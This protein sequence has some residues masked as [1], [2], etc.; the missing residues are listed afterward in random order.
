MRND[1]NYYIIALN[2]SP[3]IIRLNNEML[4]AGEEKLTSLSYID[5]LT[6]KYDEITF[7][8]YLYSKQIIKNVNA[9][10]FIVLEYTYDKQRRLKFHDI[11]FKGQYA[12]LVENLALTTERKRIIVPSDAGYLLGLF[13]NMYGKDQK[14]MEIANYIINE[15]DINALLSNKESKKRLYYPLL[16]DVVAC[17]RQYASFDCV[18]D[19][20]SS[21]Y[22]NF[23]YARDILEVLPKKI[24][25]KKTVPQ[26]ISEEEAKSIKKSDNWDNIIIKEQIR[27]DSINEQAFRTMTLEDELRAGLIN[28][29]EYIDKRYEREN[30]FS[31]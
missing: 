7:R 24:R 31:R 8:K 10:I 30:K 2:D 16:R 18:E 12:N 21:V 3:R 22:K 9:P 23:D 15:H 6:S 25:N 26:A 5:L 27:S 20:I 11:I 19:Y 29:K 1:A 14:F 4:Q 13:R 28:T 17:F